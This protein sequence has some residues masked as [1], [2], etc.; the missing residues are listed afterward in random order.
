MESHESVEIID[1]QDPQ[2]LQQ[3]AVD[4]GTSPTPSISEFSAIV[5]EDSDIEDQEPD[6]IP[7]RRGQP[8]FL[9]PPGMDEDDDDVSSVAPNRHCGVKGR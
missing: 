4:D 3:L 5:N 6:D 1:L 8:I 2:K 7:V 9:Q